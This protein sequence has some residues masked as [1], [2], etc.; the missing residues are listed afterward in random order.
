[1]IKEMLGMWYVYSKYYLPITI[2]ITIT[3]ITIDK[4]HQQ[5]S[6]PSSPSS[7]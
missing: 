1:M 5:V 4:H 2:I 3:I 6:P 7:L